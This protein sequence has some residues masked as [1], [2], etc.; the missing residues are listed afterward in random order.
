VVAAALVMPMLL[1]LYGCTSGSGSGSAL[2][3]NFFGM[4]VHRLTPDPGTAATPWPNA[5][6]GGLRLWDSGTTWAKLQ[7]TPTTWDFSKLDGQVDA[8][9][10][11]GSDVLL[12]LGQSPTWASARPGERSGY[13]L[14]ASAE[15]RDLAVWEQYV[16]TVTTRYKGRI[17]AYEIWNEPVET[18]YY[19]GTP[20]KLGE[21]TKAASTVL[22]QVDPAAKLVSAS[23]YAQ[24]PNN[25]WLR[26]YLSTGVGSFVDI[27]GVH[28]YATVP[29]V[30]LEGYATVRRAFNELGL[31]AKPVW[32][33]ETGFRRVSGGNVYSDNEMRG[34]VLR[35]HMLLA[36]Q[37]VRRVFWYAWDNQGWVGVKMTRPDSRTLAAGGIGYQQTLYALLG[38]QVLSCRAAT[39]GVSSCTVSKKGRR[40]TYYWTSA[41]YRTITL[42]G[43]T[44]GVQPFGGTWRP[45]YSA[46][47]VVVTGLPLQV[48][49]R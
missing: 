34:I 28:L 20:E 12:V 39:T 38:A 21:L 2:T 11:H 1:L 26:R 3:P 7:P 36:A 40:S 30:A 47:R 19:S 18:R 37:G 6:F 10:A 27:L 43:G 16:R 15:P 8:A 33:T 25:T 5:A 45:E 14:G 46:H 48:T 31:G 49:L 23:P 42:P 41:G 9:R 17:A 24:G 44:T 22:R 4:H 29:E 32:I 35:I 13:G